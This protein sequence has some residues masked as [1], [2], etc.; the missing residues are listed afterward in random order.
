MYVYTHHIHRSY[1]HITFHVYIYIYICDYIYTYM[2]ACDIINSCLHTYIYIQCIQCIQSEYTP[3]ITYSG[4][5]FVFSRFVQICKNRKA[6]LFIASNCTAD[7]EVQA[8]E[9]R[10]QPRN[11][12]IV[13]LVLSNSCWIHGLLVLTLIHETN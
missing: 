13:G 6:R 9:E 4:M 10:I 3:T 2:W 11:L 7:V 12:G 5:L 1:I 8:K